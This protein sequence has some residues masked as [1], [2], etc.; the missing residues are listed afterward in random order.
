MAL[1]GTPATFIE[2]PLAMI[3]I[4][5][6]NLQQYSRSV[7]E[8]NARRGT[9]LNLVSFYNSFRAQ[10]PSQT[11]MCDMYAA[12]TRRICATAQNA[13]TS[14][15]ICGNWRQCVPHTSQ[16]INVVSC[17]SLTNTIVLCKIYTTFVAD[18]HMRINVN[19]ICGRY[20]LLA[21]TCAIHMWCMCDAQWV[22][23]AVS[24]RERRCMT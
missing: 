17:Q 2:D 23:R 6:G 20:L 3:K 5:R 18:A 8:A 15:N 16:I 24:V 13:H 12:H 4:P 19:Y 11:A 10:Q 9:L 7:V 1:S 22:G 14:T 21:L